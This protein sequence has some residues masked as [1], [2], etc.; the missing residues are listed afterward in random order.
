RVWARVS[1]QMS[2]ENSLSAN[3]NLENLNT[4]NTNKNTEQISGC[5]DFQTLIPAYLEGK[6]STARTLLLEDHKNECIP[7]RRALNAERAN[8]ATQTAT[9]I[10]PQHKRRATNKQP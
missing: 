5:A 3:S 9:F 1:A 10:L 4:M 8:A 2:D 7:C 6:L